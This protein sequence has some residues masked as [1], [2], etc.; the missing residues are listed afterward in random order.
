MA[1]IRQGHTEALRHLQVAQRFGGCSR[2]DLL[3]GSA[4]VPILK[5]MT[6]PEVARL[7][8]GM[9]GKDL[10][11]R[12]TE[13]VEMA[14]NR[15]ASVGFIKAPGS[16]AAFASQLKTD[17]TTLL[18]NFKTWQKRAKPPVINE[19]K[20]GNKPE[21]LVQ[22]PLLTAWLLWVADARAVVFRGMQGFIDNQ[23]ITQ[24]AVS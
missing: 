23:T 24:V 20:R 4:R 9:R 3:G 18:R 21:V 15:P 7:N 17:Q 10:Q 22:I 11:K 5:I 16:L 12:W 1:S 19:I 14:G 2:G 13:L 6:D 8:F